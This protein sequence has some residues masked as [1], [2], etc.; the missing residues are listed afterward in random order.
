MPPQRCRAALR[1]AFPQGGW[2]APDA[3]Q[4]RPASAVRPAPEA[5]GGD[6]AVDVYKRQLHEVG[7][8][9]DVC[10]T[11][12]KSVWDKSVQVDITQLKKN[13]ASPYQYYINV[14]SNSV[15]IAVKPAA[16][17]LSYNL[18]TGIQPFKSGINFWMNGLLEVEDLEHAKAWF[19]EHRCV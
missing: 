3:P 4:V 14:E 17:T 5:G 9:R 13:S 7:D 1:A 6:Q 15:N 12:V 19:T 16:S 18:T 2:P 10:R 8:V 11:R